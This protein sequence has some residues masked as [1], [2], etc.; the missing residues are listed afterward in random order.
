[1]VAATIGYHKTYRLSADNSLVEEPTS[2]HPAAGS[3][4]ALLDELRRRQAALNARLTSREIIEEMRHAPP[5]LAGIYP[6]KVTRFTCSCECGDEDGMCEQ[7]T[8][9]LGNLKVITEVPFMRRGNIIFAIR[10]Q[11]L[12]DPATGGAESLDALFN[13]GILW[14]GTLDERAYDYDLLMFRSGRDRCVGRMSESVDLTRKLSDIDPGLYQSEIAYH[15]QTESNDAQGVPTLGRNVGDYGSAAEMEQVAACYA[16]AA[17]F[18]AAAS[19]NNGMLDELADVA[20]LA[21]T[22]VPGKRYYQAYEAFLRGIGY[23]PE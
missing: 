14:E 21:C 18:S 23:H 16:A 9:R 12:I 17:A 19:S 4:G 5:I 11:G 20:R 13:G 22:S 15:L 7:L 1:M 8:D 10:S 2:D 3:I 6:L